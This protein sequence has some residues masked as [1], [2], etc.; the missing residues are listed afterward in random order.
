MNEYL[1]KKLRILNMHDEEPNLFD[2][3]RKT[4]NKCTI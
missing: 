3:H 4:K 1:D 2:G